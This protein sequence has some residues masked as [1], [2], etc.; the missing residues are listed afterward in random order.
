MT[1][2]QGIS[3]GTE[4][5]L[6][7]SVPAP[8]AYPLGTIYINGT[9]TLFNQAIDEE[10]LVNETII[11]ALEANFTIKTR[12]YGGVSCRCVYIPKER[13]FWYVDTAT[14]INS[15]DL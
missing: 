6:L 15:R 7:T 14:G 11:A 5:I 10:Y 1:K 2:R 9:A 13:G 4:G 3:Q 12:S 8:P